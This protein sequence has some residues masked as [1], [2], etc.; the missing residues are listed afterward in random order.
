V[1]LSV[2]IITSLLGAPFFLFLL[3]R[4]RKASVL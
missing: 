4:K 2:G 1:E 3:F